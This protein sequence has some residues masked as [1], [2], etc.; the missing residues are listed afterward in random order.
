MSE[1]YICNC[2]FG[3]FEFTPYIPFRIVLEFVITGATVFVIFL[4]IKSALKL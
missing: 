4:V 2:C 3:V 1:K